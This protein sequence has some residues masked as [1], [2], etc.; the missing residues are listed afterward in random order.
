MK[1]WISRFP[2]LT[3]AICVLGIQ[4]AIIL[5][6]GAMIPEGSHLHDIPDAHMLFRFRVFTPLVFAVGITWYLE[7][8]AGLRKLFAAY[9]IWRVPGKWYAFSLT[10]KLLFCWLAWAVADLL[11][12]LPWPGFF[13]EYL[14]DDNAAHL[15]VM[16]WS[17]PFVLGLALV[18]ET[19]WMKYC[20]T[21]LQE[22]HSALFSTVLTGLIWG[23]WYLPML[24]LGEGVPDGV[25]WW[26]F[27]ANMV[28]L[29]VILGWVY[30]MT[31]SG[32]I[33]LIMQ[34]ISNVAF[35]ILP[36]LPITHDGDSS[37]VKAFVV[38]ELSMAVFIVLRYGAKD[39]GTIP[40]AKWSDPIPDPSQPIH[41]QVIDV[42]N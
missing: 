36:A 2:V 3:L 20:V 26:I 34:V 41:S 37:Y 30:N 1:A 28:A 12:I 14:F 7:G 15:K 39:M 10:W 29:A 25:A 8:G 24:L 13:L 4:F 9:R 21:R 23:L 19:T 16:M 18:E 31:H 22:N 6:A 40:R 17:M 33:L 32:L 11:G 27:I 5:I 42:S 38:V 35:F